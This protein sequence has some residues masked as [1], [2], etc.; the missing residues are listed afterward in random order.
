[1]PRPQVAGLIKRG[2]AVETDIRGDTNFVKCAI[3][4]HDAKPGVYEILAVVPVD[5]YG[6]HFKFHD[7]RTGIVAEKVMSFKL[8]GMGDGT[9]ISRYVI[10]NCQYLYKVENAR[11]LF[12]L[13]KALG[14]AGFNFETYQK[15]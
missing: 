9:V 8:V 13:Q 2:F 11:K 4:S 12:S 7:G 6:G 14:V 1:M 10:P 3:C 5:F 15:L